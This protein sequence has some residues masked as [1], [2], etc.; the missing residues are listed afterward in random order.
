MSEKL[1]LEINHEAKTIEIK[2][3]SSEDWI[4]FKN[5][6]LQDW[7][8]TFLA[9]LMIALRRITKDSMIWTHWVP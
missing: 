2:Q 5:V 6:N 1:L 8:V 4:L 3:S 9:Y 7:H